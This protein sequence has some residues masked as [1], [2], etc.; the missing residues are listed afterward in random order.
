MKRLIQLV[1][2]CAASSILMGLLV[3]QPRFNVAIEDKGDVA[4]WMPTV[5][6]S[7]LIDSS[8]GFEVIRGTNE[9][10][11]AESVKANHA[12]STPERKILGKPIVATFEA[13][14]IRAVDGDTIELLMPDK[15][16]PNCRLASI[17]CPE[18]KQA[19]GSRA[20]EALKALCVGQTVTVHQ[21]GTDGYKR[22]IV[23]VVA[24]GLNV[25][26]ELIRQGFAWHYLKYSKSDELARMESAAREAKRGLW[27][28]SLAVAPWDWRKQQQKN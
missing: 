23:F 18:R 3:Y 4:D 10:P 15:T 24:D 26:A 16:H 6:D 2:I 19:F 13:K 20:T 11:P 9:T 1:I 17:D 27:K 14:A 22:P 21:I 28:D 7:P 12:V 5:N 25:N 8:P